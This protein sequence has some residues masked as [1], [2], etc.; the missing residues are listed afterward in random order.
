MSTSNSP[1]SATPAKSGRARAPFDVDKVMGI[2]SVCQPLEDT[3]SERES[4]DEEAADDKSLNGFIWNVRNP[5]GHLSGVKLAR[6]DMAAAVLSLPEVL[7]RQA[8]LEVLAACTFQGVIELLR[9]RELP[10]QV[11]SP[12]S[13]PTF[14]QNLQVRLRCRIHLLIKVT[15]STET[16]VERH[17]DHPGATSTKE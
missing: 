4:S 6:G 3:D 17:Q 11:V 2:V 14:P 1:T 9:N 15:S 16:K 5:F 8:Q 13:D 10:R 7:N 12:K